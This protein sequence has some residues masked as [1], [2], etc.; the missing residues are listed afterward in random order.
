M[1]DLKE[2]EVIE[3]ALV[4]FKSSPDCFHLSPNVDEGFMVSGSRDTGIFEISQHEIEFIT[5]EEIHTL[6]KVP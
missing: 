4:G 5:H 3:T 6:L 1:S 2:L